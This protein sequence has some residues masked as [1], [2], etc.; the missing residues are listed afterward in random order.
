MAATCKDCGSPV[1]RRFT[2]GPAPWR[3]VACKKRV[4]RD[5][6]KMTPRRAFWDQR[7]NARHRGIEWVLSFEEWWDI[8]CESGRWERRG[9]SGY[10]MCRTGDTGPYAVGNVYIDHTS[11]NC[12]DGRLKYFQN[13]PRDLPIGV[14]AAKN[15]R[16]T[17]ARCL[18]GKRHWLGSFD[19]PE[20]AHAA[21]LSV[22]AGRSDAGV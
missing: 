11:N 6:R 13:N 21:Y 3:C 1:E 2:K 7:S 16:F 20:E 4:K 18:Y 15:G 8:W 10:V 9:R 5:S 19:S 17:A 22:G 12:R 14:W